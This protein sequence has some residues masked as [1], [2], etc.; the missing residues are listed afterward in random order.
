MPPQSLIPRLFVN[1]EI[2]ISFEDNTP[3]YY[4]NILYYQGN[5]YEKLDNLELFK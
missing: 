1:N 5:I 2:A 4:P 3:K